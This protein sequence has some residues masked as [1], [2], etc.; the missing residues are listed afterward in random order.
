MSSYLFR[1][2]DCVEN[3]PTGWVGLAI[4]PNLRS[5]FNLIDQHGD[6]YSTEISRIDFASVCVYREPPSID[7]HPD[8]LVPEI[9]KFEDGDTFA[10]AELDALTW[11][12]VNWDRVRHI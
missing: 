9:S 4:A 6:P 1:F 8:A 5:L 2:L 10:P 7:E 12:V 11:R 3:K